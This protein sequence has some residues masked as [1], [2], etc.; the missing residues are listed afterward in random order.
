M[1]WVEACG[2]FVEK[3]HIW[4]VDNA[5]RDHG[6]ALHSTGNRAQASSAVFLQ[7][8]YPQGVDR[9]VACCCAVHPAQP[10]NVCYE[11]HCA[12]RRIKDT[13]LRNPADT[14]PPRVGTADVFTTHEDGSCRRA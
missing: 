9:V 5:R 13:A 11:I 10:S 6:A 4:L 3:Q 2:G 12:L 1:V 8:H 14:L 7:A